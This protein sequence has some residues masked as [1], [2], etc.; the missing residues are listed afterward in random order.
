MKAQQWC[1]M[2]M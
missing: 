1:K 2:V